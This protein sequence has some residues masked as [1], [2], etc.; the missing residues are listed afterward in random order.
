MF[1]AYVMRTFGIQNTEYRVRYTRVAA[2]SVCMK[3]KGER[4]IKAGNSTKERNDR[5]PA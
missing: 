4:K 5:V 2:R 3:G 1:R